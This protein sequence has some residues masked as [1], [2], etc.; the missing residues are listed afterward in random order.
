LATAESEGTLGRETRKEVV[1]SKLLERKLKE[2]NPGI[3]SDQILQVVK[4]FGKDRSSM[5]EVR[6]NKETL[7]FLR[8]GVDLEIRGSDGKMKQETV[9]VIDWKRPENNEFLL[10]SQLWISGDYGTKRPDLVGFIN[11]VPVL[12]FELKKP[13]G[14]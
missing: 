7:D 1:L 8:E 14:Q 2:L 11:G 5:H 9:R 12:L 10:V 6:A 13:A 4:E 3:P